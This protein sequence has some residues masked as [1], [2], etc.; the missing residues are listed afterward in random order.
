MAGR[1]RQRSP[2]TGKKRRSRALALKAPLA[3]GA[4]VEHIIVLMLENRSFDFMLGY[5]KHPN[6]A[7]PNVSDEEFNRLGPVANPTSPKIF[8]TPTG[9]PRLELSPDHSHRGVMQQLFGVP[10][11]TDPGGAP[12]MS[13]FVNDYEEF[14]LNKLGTSGNGQLIM[15]CLDS[16]KVPVLSHLATVI[17]HFA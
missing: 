11:S 1:T 5:L 8:V 3:T 13:G 14:A 2:Q 4:K 16:R 9:T 10:L 12:S 17:G 6:L 7:F 15:G